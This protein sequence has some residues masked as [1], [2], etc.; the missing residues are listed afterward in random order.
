[1]MNV[2]F[3]YSAASVSSGNVCS[4][5]FLLQMFVFVLIISEQILITSNQ[6]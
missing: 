2:V 4:E 1:M 3:I 5:A 6:D